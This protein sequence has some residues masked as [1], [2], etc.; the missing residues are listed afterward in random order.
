MGDLHTHLFWFLAF[1]TENSQS[2]D[3]RTGERI[4]TLFGDQE[5]AVFACHTGS[6]TS[7]SFGEER[8]GFL[9]RCSPGD[10]SSSWGVTRCNQILAYWLA[11]LSR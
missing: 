1:A 5:E 8:D 7:S 11:S 6:A 10:H 9:L 4:P 3:Q 2:L